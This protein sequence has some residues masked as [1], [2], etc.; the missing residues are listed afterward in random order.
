MKP[1]YISYYTEG[2]FYEEV[3]QGLS[4]SLK[5]FDLAHKIYAKPDFKDWDKNV[6]QKPRVIADALSEFSQPVVWM[7]A[8]AIIEKYPAVFDDLDCDLGCHIRTKGGF[9][10]FGSTLYFGNTLISKEMVADWVERCDRQEK[11]LDI[12]I[13]EP[14]KRISDVWAY[15]DQGPLANSYWSFVL[16]GKPIRIFDLPKS[17]AVK[18]GSNYAEQVIVHNQVSRLY[19]KK[20]K[21]WE[22]KNRPIKARSERG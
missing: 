14:Y 16:A 15:A 10:I 6:R 12:E 4:A 3:A 20:T 19:H 5:K 22:L 11:V 7:D 21:D 2:T 13:P 9:G 17:Y 18:H 8:D 1:V